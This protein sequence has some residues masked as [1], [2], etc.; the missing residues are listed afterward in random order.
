MV[1]PPGRC[2]FCT[3][4]RLTKEHLFA[5]WLRELF[6]RSASDTHTMGEAEGE[7]WRII[8]R[9]GHSGS[10]KIRAVCDTCNNGWISGIDDAAKHAA[11]SLI[12]G[13][14]RVVTPDMQRTLSSWFAKIAAVADSRDRR[15]SKV[16]QRQRTWLME[17]HEPPEEWE[18]WIASYGG[19]DYRDLALFQNGGH[20]DFSPVSG[21]SKKLAGYAQ[22]TFLGLGRLAVLV[23]AHDFRAVD[24]SVGT[25]AQI[26]RRIWPVGAEFGWPFPRVL[27]DVEA[28]AAT[29][30]LNDM[31]A[32]IRDE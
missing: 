18:I 7:P 15:R 5:D 24:F 32:N 21:P 28:N 8:R 25:Y 16:T 29:R 3:G 12:L 2:I 31:V 30:I 4:F 9:Q 27:T 22:T 1:K 26:G 23:I 20:L 6:P 13:E 17:H 19:A 10:K 11:T 14:A